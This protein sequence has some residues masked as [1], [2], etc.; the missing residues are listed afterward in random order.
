VAAKADDFHLL[1]GVLMNLEIQSLIVTHGAV[2][3][4]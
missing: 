3:S 2:V 4:C 1:D